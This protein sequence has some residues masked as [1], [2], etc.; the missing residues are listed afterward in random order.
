M[1][2]F[3]TIGLLA[4]GAV[5]CQASGP[6]LGGAGTSKDIQLSNSMVRVLSQSRLVGHANPS[7]RIYLGVNL[8]PRHLPELEAFC[9]AVSDPA[10]PQ[11][12]QFMTPAEVGETFGASATDVAATA[13]WL[14]SQ[15]MQVD[16][17]A[18][19]RMTICVW[20]TVGQAEKA[21]GVK[22]NTYVGPDPESKSI[23][24]RANAAPLTIPSNLKAVTFIEGVSNYDR[25][26]PM[27]TTLSPSLAR[28]LYNVKPMFDANYRGQGRKIGYSNWDGWKISNGVG[29]INYF[30][31][32][33]P[34]GGAGSNIHPVNAGQNHQ[35][36]N[37]AGE[38]DLDLQMELAMA[39]LA[40]I[41]VYDGS[42]L[43]PVLSKEATDN[44]DI[45][46]ESWGWSGG[47][48]SFNSAHNIHLSMTAQ[49]MTYMCAS[50]DSGASGVNGTYWY[51]GADP[52][53]LCVGGTVATTNGSGNRTSEFGWNGS[54]G[55]WKNN[56]APYNHLPSWQTGNG[57]LTGIDK[58]LQPDIG[59]HSDASNGAYYMWYNGSLY[60]ISGTSC[61]SPDTAGAL[62]IVEQ[63]LAA[64]G[65]TSRLGRIQD[66][67]YSM[68]GR[69]DVWYDITS[70]SNGTLPNGQ[71][72]TCHAGWDTVTG[73]GAPN[74]DGFY[75]AIA[76]TSVEINPASYSIFRG[77]YIS[78]D[79][80]SLGSSDNN[81]LD[82][83]RGFVAN[84][85]E[86]PVDVTVVGQ[87]SV[88]AVNK[89]KVHIETHANT[90]G[91]TQYLYLWNYSSNAWDVVDTRSGPTSDTAVD[92]TI[93]SGAANYVSAGDEVKARIG[94]KPTGLLS[95]SAWHGY[96]D[97]VHWTIN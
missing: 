33:V 76:A 49:G 44:Y 16:L 22:V 83:K 41:Y 82:V 56:T 19:N 42:S 3:V 5:M 13:A 87:G 38:G 25:P 11:Y 72:S 92:V 52:E 12:R 54:G 91:L 73:W 79:V 58:R 7:E 81:Y 18:P 65:Q 28:T 86:N 78:G 85:G 26:K 64:N 30:G 97:Q 74:W 47:S 48:T 94:L 53:V 51:P 36:V 80:N 77:V 6:Q 75:N 60:G 63:R 69:S 62:A 31:L 46:S 40:D 59:S 45:I 89:V 39:P 4:L 67:V 1:M 96:I 27:S 70:G 14:R 2:K 90:P 57:V 61:A 32:P 15:G 35:G 43:T 8:Q 71:S 21:F 93:T 10:S 95:N 9:D 50:G 37:G 29:Y 23:T 20:T 34:G 24:Y 55:G 66:L 68:N 17:I 84:G 88:G